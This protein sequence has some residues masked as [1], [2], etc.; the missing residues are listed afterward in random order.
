M[1]LNSNPSFM[2]PV[3]MSF[4][5][6][7]VL[8]PKF[9]RCILIFWVFDRRPDGVRF[10]LFR[11][12]LANGEDEDE[13]DGDGDDGNGEDGNGE[14]GDGEDVDGDD[15]EGDEGDGN[16]GIESSYETFERS[17]FPSMFSATRICDPKESVSFL[18]VSVFREFICLC[19]RSSV[20]QN[21]S[22]RF[23]LMYRKTVDFKNAFTVRSRSALNA[24]LRAPFVAQSSCEKKRAKAGR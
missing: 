9:F 21:T 13:D 11:R 14:D 17:S 10:T 6:N 8:I 16:E 7:S 18:S 12:F 24:I 2:L 23:C 3:R 22:Y 4:N 15:G 20:D 19:S 1:L 5:P